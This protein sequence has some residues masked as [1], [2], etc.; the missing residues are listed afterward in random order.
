[1]S[2]GDTLYLVAWE[3]WDPSYNSWEPYVNITDDDLIAEYE[4]RADAAEDDAEQEE[5]DAA[6]EDAA[7]EVAAQGAAAQEAAVP[8]ATEPM[9]SDEAGASVD[10]DADAPPPAEQMDTEDAAAPAAPTVPPLE[11]RSE[12][13]ACLPRA[14]VEQMVALEAG[15]MSAFESNGTLLSDELKRWD[16]T[17][18]YTADTVSDNDGKVLG[19]VVT[20]AEGRGAS[21]KVFIYHLHV[22]GTVRK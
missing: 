14:V 13:C 20:G 8:P 3:G 2:V 21:S 10:A 19:F 6:E 9:E 12:L 4:A 11:F 16:L 1:M 17:A 7:E 5:K 18:R 22:C 15:N